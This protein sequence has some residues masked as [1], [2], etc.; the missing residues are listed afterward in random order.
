EGRPL[1]GEAVV[2]GDQLLCGLTILDDGPDLLGDELAPLCVRAGIQCQIGVVADELRE[3]GA[4]PHLLEEGP[5]FLFRVVEGGA[6][7]RGRCGKDGCARTPVAVMRN[8]ARSSVPSLATTVHLPDDSSYTAEV[9]LAPNRI[10]RRR[11][12]RSTTWLR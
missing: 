4:V 6:I 10:W 9:T 2:L 5:P 11:S 8:W 1:L 3:A 7:V 12:N